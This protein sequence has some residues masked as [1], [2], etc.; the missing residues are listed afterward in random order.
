[1]PPCMWS[2]GRVRASDVVVITRA[3]AILHRSSSWLARL[4]ALVRSIFYGVGNIDALRCR[5]CEAK[6]RLHLQILVSGRS[7]LW[8]RPAAALRYHAA[9]GLLG[10]QE[11]LAQEWLPLASR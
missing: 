6:E 1:M 11:S 10:I 9:S 8:P 3:T 7:P 4:K 5:S 2:G